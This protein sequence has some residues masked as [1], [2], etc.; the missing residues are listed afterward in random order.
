MVKVNGLRVS[1]VV[2]LN[3]MGLKRMRLS[4]KATKGLAGRN[5][6]QQCFGIGLKNSVDAD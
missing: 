3:L 5:L 6:A 4:S 2:G 1:L